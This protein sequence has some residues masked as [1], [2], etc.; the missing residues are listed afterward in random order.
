M[1][2]S[3]LSI[4]LSFFSML[5]ALDPDDVTVTDPSTADDTNGD[6]EEGDVDA[7][8]DDANEDGDEDDMDE[9]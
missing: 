9:G 3:T 4:D 6:G 5:F 7:D 8:L 2:T 1:L